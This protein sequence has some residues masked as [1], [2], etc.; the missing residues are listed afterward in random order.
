[1]VSLFTLIQRGELKQQGAF[2]QEEQGED[3]F[4]V[5]DPA[6]PQAAQRVDQ[7]S[8]GSGSAEAAP[9]PA[10]LAIEEGRHRLITP[11]GVCVISSALAVAHPLEWGSSTAARQYGSTKHRMKRS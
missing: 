11:K 5:P 9:P 6:N 4:G 10:P 8:S 2:R 1:M 7:G 3:P